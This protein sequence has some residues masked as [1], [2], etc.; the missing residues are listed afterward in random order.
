MAAV[1]A[2]ALAVAAAAPASADG[3]FAAMYSDR[4]V[5]LQALARERPPAAPSLQVTGISVPHHLLA[6]DLIAR[7]FW[8]AAG[9]KYDRIVIL[10]PDHFNRSRRPLATTRRDF[11]TVFGRI[12]NDPAATGALL[13]A[14]DL[15][16]DSDLFA[17]EHGIAA[18]L[19]F[20]KH[21]F[22]DARIVP[23]VISFGA[24][25]ADW[26]RALA[27]V[28]RLIG[29]RVLVVQSTD[30][31]HYLS[32]D[33]ARQRDQETLNVIAAN[34]AD[35]LVRLR[36]PAHMDSKGAQYLQMQLQGGTFKSHAT[37]VANRNSNAYG[38][39]GA[40]TTSYI[41]TAY[42]QS[43]PVGAQLR[44]ADQE[45]IYFA[46]DTFLGRWLTAP[47][48]DRDV[49]N[50]VVNEVRAIT[51]GAPLVVNL[52]GVLLDEPPEGIGSDFHVMHAGLAIPVLTA[53][54]VKAAG[55]ANNHS[56][57]LG[58]SGYQE[59]RSILAR[60]GI[61][62]LGHKDVLDLGSLRLLGLNFIGKTDYRDY[63]VAR[64]NDIEDV[65][66]M[67]ARPPLIALVHWGRE[68]TATAGGAEYAAAQAL[69]AC[70]VSAI[71]GAHSH[72]AAPRIEALQG[73]EYALT[74]SLGNFLFDQKAD[75]SSSALLEL[76][77][78]KQ[79][80]YAA[81]LIALPNLFELATSE[82]ARKQGPRRAD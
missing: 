51:A 54:N 6:A 59:S 28:E 36:Q 11:D 43:P 77:L 63:P 53:L 39:D 46:G 29:P 5:F 73:G 34:D 58:P 68:F 67:R 22:P 26:D 31:S 16:D 27:L 71:V 37:V 72:Q 79:G 9:N 55:L 20:V 30:Y 69:E 42:T 12:E 10:S 32:P 33:V 13:N 4:A 21:F 35:T 25:R 66:R 44:F 3:A 52:E 18:L 74:Y 61:A 81:R 80:T 62:P 76:R 8:I 70:G 75:R 57:D 19:P 64:G 49:A 15:F 23:I 56:F 14:S 82:L 65:C 17:T 50:R 7:G 60:S 47:L 40:K 24:S 2:F 41:V 38:A 1:M 45:V 48:A 78:F